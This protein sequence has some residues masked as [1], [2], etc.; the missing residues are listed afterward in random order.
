MIFNKFAGLGIA[1]ILLFGSVGELAINAQPAEALKARQATTAKAELLH[2]NFRHHR[3][4][5]LRRNYKRNFRHHRKRSFIRNYKGNFR[6][7]GKRNFRHHGRPRFRRNYR[8][9]G[10]FNRRHNLK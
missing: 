6:H 4:R 10:R 3:K 5:S 9:H 7:H 1:S 8:H 2:E